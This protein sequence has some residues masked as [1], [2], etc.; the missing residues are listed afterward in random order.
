MDELKLESSVPY[1][2]NKI[3]E[4]F[5]SFSPHDAYMELCYQQ[6]VKV[7]R[8]VAKIFP[9][10]LGRWEDVTRIDLSH[11]Y[12][13]PKG[14][15]VILQMCKRL[16]SLTFL[17]AADHHLNNAS[18]YALTCMALYHP[19][20]A[21]I[22][23]RGN[24]FISWSGGM[25]LTE[26]AEKNTVV[27]SIQV[28]Y[29]NIDHQRQ[30]VLF[31]QTRLNAAIQF[32]I[33]GTVNPPDQQ[34]VIHVRAMKRFFAEIQDEN[35]TVPLNAV[36]DGFQEYLRI[37]GRQQ[38]IGNY[39]ET[40]FQGLLAR[41]PPSC[42]RVDWNAFVI[43]LFCPGA[44]YDGQIRDVLRRAFLD[45]NVEESL[46]RMPYSSLFATSAIPNAAGFSTKK[47]PI[48]QAKDLW[49][50]YERIQHLFSSGEHLSKRRKSFAGGNSI[51]GSLGGTRSSI[52]FNHSVGSRV[53]PREAGRR[54]SLFP[55]RTATCS[56]ASTAA[57]LPS[58]MTSTA[59][60]RATTGSTLAFPPAALS[61][62]SEAEMT[63]L[64]G[65]LGIRREATL[66][67]DEFLLIFYPRGPEEGLKTTGVFDSPLA[68]PDALRHF[69]L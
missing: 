54:G 50:I 3:K 17:G 47:E 46:R 55:S 68:L 52:S 69:S 34:H 14:F 9:V 1:D 66:S 39:T 16:P 31:E 32:S 63:A 40:F 36:I 21:E 37:M 6:K 43:L 67:W 58:T 51:A 13:G 11:T 10:A 8:E 27:T 26:L 18:V 19:S 20:L 53:S 38:E 28:S 23:L 62:P 42:A 57:P 64:Y 15:E 12:V 2:V 30:E 49:L 59:L 24:R 60:P 7:N 4:E 44:S 48:V 41:A 35:G 56:V 25:W 22:D 45:F 5:H 29:T 65:R 33:H 61:T